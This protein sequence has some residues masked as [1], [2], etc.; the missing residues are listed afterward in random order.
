MTEMLL[1]PNSRDPTN[2]S[3]IN[4][5]M[6]KQTVVRS[7]DANP[8]PKTQVQMPASS[9]AAFK[10]HPLVLTPYY[11]LVVYISQGQNLTNK[12]NPKYTHKLFN[13]CFL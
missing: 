1:D 12:H 3:P 8:H 9:L 5:A 4:Y 13:I 7:F 11:Q 10:R 2:Q 6:P